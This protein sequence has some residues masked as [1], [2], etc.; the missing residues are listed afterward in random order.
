MQ[1]APVSDRLDLS[2]AYG[3]LDA[4]CT[5]INLYRLLAHMASQLPSATCRMPLFKNVVRGQVEIMISTTGALKAI[6]GYL[7]FAAAVGSSL[8]VL[9]AAYRASDLARKGLGDKTKPFMIT[10]AKGPK[11]SAGGTLRVDT[12]P[13][14]YSEAAVTEAVCTLCILCLCTTDGCVCMCASVRCR[15]VLYIEFSRL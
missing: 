13:L 12:S 7:E 6:R 14:G 11:L 2:K 3:R 1:V 9:E 5:V 15:R 4:V 8:E 10:A